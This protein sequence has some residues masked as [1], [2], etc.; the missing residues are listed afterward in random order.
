MVFDGL[1]INR[2]AYIPQKR[3]GVRLIE[4]HHMSCHAIR[5]GTCSFAEMKWSERFKRCY[6][7]KHHK[8]EGLT[9]CPTD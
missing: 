5:I 3:D 4:G 8:L 9:L 7:D 6:R 1:L 2:T